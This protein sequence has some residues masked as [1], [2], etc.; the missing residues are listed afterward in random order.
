MQL[1]D[2]IVMLFVV[3]FTKYSANTVFRSINFLNLAMYSLDAICDVSESQTAE[4][5]IG[6]MHT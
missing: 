1:R 2:R 5:Y 4:L 3:S 6:T